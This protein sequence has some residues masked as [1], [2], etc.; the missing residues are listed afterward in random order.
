MKRKHGPM[1]VKI[2]QPG[3]IRKTIQLMGRGYTLRHALKIAHQ[4]EI[5]YGH[6]ARG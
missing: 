4:K 2:K 6:K 3:Y 5:G 1:A